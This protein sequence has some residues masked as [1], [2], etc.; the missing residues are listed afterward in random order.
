MKERNQPQGCSVS[1]PRTYAFILAPF[2]TERHV[3]SQGSGQVMSQRLL[4]WIRYFFPPVRTFSLFPQRVRFVFSLALVSA[5]L[6]STEQGGDR[7]E[8]VLLTQRSGLSPVHYYV[9]LAMT[10]TLR[11][12]DLIPVGEIYFP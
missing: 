10:Q 12:R 9:I 8:Q 4:A 3:L 7:T 1:F 2:L 11:V 5:D 6:F